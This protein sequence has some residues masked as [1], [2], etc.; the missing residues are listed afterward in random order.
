MFLYLFSFFGILNILFWS[1]GAFYTYKYRNMIKFLYPFLINFDRVNIY[2]ALQAF[3][4]QNEDAVL[5][6]GGHVLKIPY[7]YM[8]RSYTLY[9]PYHRSKVITML[10]S[11][12]KI[13]K[14]KKDEII[15]QQPGVPLFITARQ[16]LVD[17][18]II[19]NDETDE[20]KEYKDDEIIHF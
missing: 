17:R 14:N 2:E 4:S 15:K 18:I 7:T 9:I 13:E 1:V 3:G 19:I 11:T 8:K 20:I 6:S 12:I 16:L 10:N 5:V